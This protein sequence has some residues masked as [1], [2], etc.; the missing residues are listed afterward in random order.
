MSYLVRCTLC[1]SCECWCCTKGNL[2]KV[3][4]VLK[5]SSTNNACNIFLMT[6]GYI[7]GHLTKHRHYFVN[8]SIRSNKG[9]SLAT[10]KN[11]SMKWFHQDI[12]FI[13]QC[14]GFS[15]NIKISIN[16]SVMVWNTMHMLFVSAIRHFA[17][18]LLD[19]G[20]QR[21]VLNLLTWFPNKSNC[22]I[23]L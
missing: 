21:S 6:K 13:S 19:D 17:S 15:R 14:K 16:V 18:I 4:T 9:F 5:T 22:M 3:K 10:S 20:P 7:W 2:T 8:L 23:F 1:T 11:I 12:C